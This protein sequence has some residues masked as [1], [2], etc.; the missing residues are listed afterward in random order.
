MLKINFG[1]LGGGGGGGGGG[2][3]G[4][5]TPGLPTRVL[6]LDPLGACGPQT[7]GLLRD[8]GI[9]SGW[10]KGPPKIPGKSL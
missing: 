1:L 2:G 7:S 5:H 9:F 8:P 10:A 3:R 4:L 6:P